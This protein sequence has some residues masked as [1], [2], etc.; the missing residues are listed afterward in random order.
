MPTG[1]GKRIRSRRKELGLSQEALAERL[2]L[3]SKST[4]CKIERGDDNLTADTVDKYAKALNCV[5]GY[6]MGWTDIPSGISVDPSLASVES[7][8]IPVAVR[9]MPPKKDHSEAEALYDLYK[10]ASPEIQQAVEIL[11]KKAA[12]HS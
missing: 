6:L 3:K 12:P 4:V 5:P 9:R 7:G 11:L 2:G 10:N 8:G 1:L